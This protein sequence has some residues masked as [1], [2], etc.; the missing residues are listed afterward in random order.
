MTEAEYEAA[1]ARIDALMDGDPEPACAAG[2]ELEIL[3]LLVGNYEAVHYP[4]VWEENLIDGG[5]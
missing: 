3:C 2:E 1:L 5:D 4:M